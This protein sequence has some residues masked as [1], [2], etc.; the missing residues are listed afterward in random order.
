MPPLGWREWI[1]GSHGTRVWKKSLFTLAN[2]IR[3]KKYVFSF[4]HW[5][6]RKISLRQYIYP[7]GLSLSLHGFIILDALS[8]VPFLGSAVKVHLG[9]ISLVN[10][11]KVYLMEDLSYRSQ[12]KHVY[13]E[14]NRF[15]DTLAALEGDLKIR[16]LICFHLPQITFFVFIN[17]NYSVDDHVLVL[18]TLEIASCHM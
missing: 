10:H 8:V 18:N 5:T 16:I 4:T 1:E 12:F 15:D 2:F 13:K 11:F 14:A 9:L 6:P 7:F 3:N 17:F